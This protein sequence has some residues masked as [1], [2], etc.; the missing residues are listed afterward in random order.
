MLPIVYGGEADSSKPN[1]VEYYNSGGRALIFEKGGET[2]RVKGVDPF[3]KLTERVSS[4]A[5]NRIE[6]VSGA[7]FIASTEHNI[8]AAREGKGMIF[9]D[10]KPF[11]VLYKEQAE[12]EEQ[13]FQELGRIYR[14]L[15]I[16]ALVNL[17][18]PWT[19]EYRH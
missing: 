2:Y 3:G 17:P 12:R 6:N 11:G 18:S 1:A 16:K 10:D 9:L 8:A 14:H 4:S 15:G 5:N 19:Q 7:L 13:A